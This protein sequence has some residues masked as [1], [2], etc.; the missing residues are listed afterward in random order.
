MLFGTR[1]GWKA[2]MTT[3]PSWLEPARSWFRDRPRLAFVAELLAVYVATFAVM[4]QVQFQTEH[5]PGT[6]GYYHIKISWLYRTEGILDSKFPWAH[7][8]FWRDT[9]YDKDFGFHVLLMPFT[10]GDLVTGAKWAAVVYGSAVYLSLF[11]VLRLQKVRFA[12]LWWLVLMATGGYFGWRTGVPRPQLLAMILAIWSL[13]AVF[14]RSWKAC[15]ALGIVFSLS[16][17][18]PFLI[19]LYALIVG[20]LYFVMKE[21]LNWKVPAAALAGVMIGWLL[22]PHFPNN[23]ILTKVQIFDVLQST[24]AKG[25]TPDLH[26]GGE[27]A[28]AST[29]DFLREHQIIFVALVLVLLAMHRLSDKMRPR[30]IS[31]LA[32]T[33]AWLILASASKRFVE[34]FVPISVWFCAK[35]ISDAWPSL[36]RDPPRIWQKGWLQT[37]IVITLSCVLAYN[38]A[39]TYREN[40]KNARGPQASGYQPVAEWL[41]DNTPADSLI[42]TC[43]WDDAPELFHYNHRNRYVVFLD[44][45]FMYR[46]N[47][48]VWKDWHRVANGRDPNPVMWLESRFQTM[49]GACTGDFQNLRK[50]LEAHDRVK[51][52]SVGNGFVFRITPEP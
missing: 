33:C 38:V 45:N 29:L 42:F 4:A 48:A 43:D 39:R 34:Y 21:E 35:A 22:H 10:F 47:K 24:W 7:F 6:D 30:L 17:T 1:V 26:L 16:Y 8:S 20:V 13:Y 12:F 49:Y 32:L 9:F 28:P 15:L 50:Q 27:L 2:P 14:E 36:Q 46:W 44:P 31:L 5:M 25:S 52:E 51:V 40:R 41:A 18:A 23:F 3:L 37:G 11:A 19:V